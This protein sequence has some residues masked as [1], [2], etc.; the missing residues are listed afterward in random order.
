M[1]NDV[2]Q[3]NNDSTTSPEGKPMMSRRRFTGAGA[4][5]GAVMLTLNN[6]A[7][8]GSGGGSDSTCVSRS[9]YVSYIN[10][11][12]SSVAKHQGAME[13]FMDKVDSGRYEE[14]FDKSDNEE[15]CIKKKSSGGGD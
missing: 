4:M 7:A 5:T 15:V 6:R 1:D 8:W 2:D 11:N 3:L 12:P 14:D 10:G 9:M 13:D